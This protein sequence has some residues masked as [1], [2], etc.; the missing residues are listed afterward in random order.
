[1]RRKIRL[2]LVRAPPPILWTKN[3]QK[4]F[5]HPDMKIYTPIDRPSQADKKR[6]VSNFF[7]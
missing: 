2:F 6:A 5:S 1:M 4:F 7:E 3:G